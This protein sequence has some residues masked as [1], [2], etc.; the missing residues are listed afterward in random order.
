MDKMSRIIRNNDSGRYAAKPERDFFF[1]LSWGN[2]EHGSGI[3]EFNSVV[4][5]L[6]GRLLTFFSKYEVEM[7][8]L[9]T[10]LKITPE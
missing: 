4:Y 2:G 10:N 3:L 8:V 1:A 6:L 5:A 7:R 9:V